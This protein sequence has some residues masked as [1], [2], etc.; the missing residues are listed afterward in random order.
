MFTRLL[1]SGVLTVSYSIDDADAA[2]ITI[3][4]PPAFERSL[5]ELKVKGTVVTLTH[6]LLL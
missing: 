5:R 4:D 2:D 1:E 6:S 3:S